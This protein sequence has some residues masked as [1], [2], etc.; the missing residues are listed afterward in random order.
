MFDYIEMELHAPDGYKNKHVLNGAISNVSEKS[1]LVKY[2]KQTK[3]LNVK[4]NLPYFMQGHN[5]WFSKDDTEKAIILLSNKLEVDLFCAE[6]KILEYG[7]VVSP[8]FTMNEFIETHLKTKGYKRSIWE[9]ETLYYTKTGK[10]YKLKFYDIWA[11]INNSRNKVSR[12]VRE[13]LEKG[14]YSRKTLPMRYEVHGN[15]KYYTN[16]ESIYVSDILAPQ[17]EVK[18]QEFLLTEYRKIN[19]WERLKV[20]GMSKFDAI[21][22]EMVLLSEK[23]YN[24]QENILSTIDRVDI[25]I[26]SKNKA[27]SEFRKRFKSMPSEKCSSS[28]EQLIIEAFDRRNLP[29]AK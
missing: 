11:N 2:N 1:M 15:P 16:Q 6:V 13:T 8:S 21:Q 22:L 3:K 9:E 14:I 7:V 4:G 10:K 24:Y 12:Q 17:F 27:K 29:S 5:F 23:D 18:C 25:G 19:K 28:I 20:D 26:H